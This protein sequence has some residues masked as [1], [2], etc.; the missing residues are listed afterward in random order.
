MAIGRRTLL[1][2][3][4]ILGLGAAGLIVELRHRQAPRETSLIGLWKFDEGNGYAAVDSSG[5]GND[6]IVV[7]T[8]MAQ[9]GRDQFAGSVLLFGG[10]GNHVRIPATDSINQI[11]K[12]LTVTAHVYPL[13]LS[14]P[15]SSGFV[16]VV[17]RQWRR[18]DHPDQY[19]LGYGT[20]NGVLKY[21]W[22]VGLQDSEPAIY[23]LPSGVSAPVINRW[24]HLAGTFD[25]DSGEMTLYVDG[26]PI[27]HQVPAGEIR[28][29][30]ESVARPLVIGAELNGDSIDDASD[31]FDGYVEEVRLYDRALSAAE[32]K[33]LAS[34]ARERTGQPP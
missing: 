20:E 22:H 21:K 23:E 10:N 9:W 14:S 2:G 34:E 11:R 16:A 5:N 7:P 1:A 12:Q 15:G 28:L 19:Y 26:D 25:G 4:A 6:G 8:P 3:G 27:G 29:D 13:V 31:E 18:E 24:V 17:Q 33:S 32:I 30:A